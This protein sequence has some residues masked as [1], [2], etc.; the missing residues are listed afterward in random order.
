MDKVKL[1]EKKEFKLFGKKIF[2]VETQ[3]E[4]CDLENLNPL[5][6]V[7]ELPVLFKKDEKKNGL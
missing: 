3:F 2:E 1:I 7:V 5:D 4:R 6:P